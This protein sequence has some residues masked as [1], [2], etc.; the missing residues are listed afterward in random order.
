MGYRTSDVPDPEE[1]DIYRPPSSTGFRGLSP[2]PPSIS[3][4]LDVEFADAERTAIRTVMTEVTPDEHLPE[5]PS[6]KVRAL[7]KYPPERNPDGTLRPVWYLKSTQPRDA[8]P[9]FH[10]R[11]SA[12]SGWTNRKLRERR[13]LD[14][15]GGIYLFP[16][17]RSLRSRVMGERV[18]PDDDSVVASERR[19]R[20]LSLSWFSLKWRVAVFG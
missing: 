3:V 9:W 6:G 15:I 5:L 13:L 2:T 1:L 11:R 17:D 8:V 10:G 7:W 16:Q 14:E 12:I 18:N 19:G 4:T 20:D